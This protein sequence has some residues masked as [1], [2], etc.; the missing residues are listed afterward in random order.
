MNLNPNQLLWPVQIC[1]LVEH[2]ACL[3]LKGMARY[4]E[5]T[6]P[7]RCRQANERRTPNDR[8]KPKQSTSGLT[9][10][11]GIAIQNCYWKIVFRRMPDVRSM[12]SRNP[13]AKEKEY[14]LFAYNAQLAFQTQF[15]LTI[16]TSIN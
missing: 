14:I 8:R 2:I 6:S 4:V 13:Y 3:I 11:W 15:C 12:A 9:P 10:G 5:K 16:N 7:A 1:L